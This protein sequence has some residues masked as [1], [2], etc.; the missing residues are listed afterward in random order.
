MIAWYLTRQWE[1][2]TATEVDQLNN[3]W[4]QDNNEASL[5]EW[6]I[7]VIYF[8]GLV[9][10]RSMQQQIAQLINAM[11]QP[12]RR[13]MT[14]TRTTRTLT[15]TRAR[16]SIAR[17]NRMVQSLD[18]MQTCLESMATRLVEAQQTLIQLRQEV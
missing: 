7:A 12:L 13:V 11:I 3:Y 9:T 5:L 14:T 4:N 15:T 2:L 1:H 17:R 6:S 18:Q 16:T 10:R 8:I